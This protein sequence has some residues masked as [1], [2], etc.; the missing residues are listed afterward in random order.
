LEEETEMTLV[1]QSKHHFL[2][3]AS[4][5]RGAR[6]FVK[7]ALRQG[8]TVT[9]LCRAEDHQAAL[10]RMKSILEKT[11]LTEGGEEPVQHHGHL[12][13]RNLNI[14]DPESYSNLIANNPSIDRVCC[15]V[16]VT[17]VRHMMS[18]TFCLYTRTIEA[19]IEGMR[20][21]RW[22]DFFY[23]GSSGVEGL[24]GQSKPQLPDNFRP[25]WILNLGLKIPAAQD[26]F[27]SETL[28]ASAQFEGLNFV[29]F[30]PA[31]LTSSPAKR[32]YGYCFDYTGMDHKQLPLRST[33]TT[34][35]REDVAEEIFRVCLLPDSR[36]SE[37]YG[38]GVYLVDKKS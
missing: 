21:S 19:L 34:I 30:R 29:V 26:C 37:W 18:R 3:I 8:H 7:K 4:A 35:S 11:I 17:T 33:K 28:L 23:H 2:V 22:V 10:I 20:R 36:R 24:P 1:N 14:L 6:F 13:A 32:S 5:S 31:W 9:A 16:G 25:K 38:H 15:F 12:Y 27:E